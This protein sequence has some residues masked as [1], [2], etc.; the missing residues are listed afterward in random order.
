[1]TMPAQ[2]PGTSRQ[3]FATPA[4]FIEAV[5]R[6]FGQLA[7]DLAAHAEN[8]KCGLRY[9]G[10]GSAHGEDSLAV[11]W[12]SFLQIGTLWLNPPFGK[13]DPWAVKCAAEAPKRHG[14]ILMLTPAS[15]GANWFAANV[16]GKAYVLALSP[17][18]SF[19]GKAPF[20]KDCVLSVWGHGLRGFDT[21][22][23]DEVAK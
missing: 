23:W 9:F 6:R 20:P 16:Q 17:R 3:D 12:S 5:E 7:W 10:P 18:L 4:A 22:R 8:S 2:K 13:I 14:L 1:M 11:G 15:V 19:D 21:W